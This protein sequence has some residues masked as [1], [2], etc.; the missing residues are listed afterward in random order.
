MSI[1]CDV[2]WCG[3]GLTAAV[4]DALGALG[5]SA[6]ATAVRVHFQRVAAAVAESGAATAFLASG[7]PLGSAGGFGFR[8]ADNNARREVAAGDGVAHSDRTL[9]RRKQRNERLRLRVVAGGISE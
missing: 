9:Q 3:F 6:A 1:V 2:D 4:Q 8:F 5:E 7:F